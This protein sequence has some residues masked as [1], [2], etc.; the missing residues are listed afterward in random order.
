MAVNITFALITHINVL[1]KNTVLLCSYLVPKSQ[2]LSGKQLY[3]T[4]YLTGHVMLLR[5]EGGNIELLLIYTTLFSFQALVE[6]PSSEAKK[7]YRYL[8]ID[9]DKSSSGEML[10]NM[11]LF[12]YFFQLKKT[13]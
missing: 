10:I 2:A 6:K 9:E 13:R 4:V 1:N 12:I 5:G 7:T 3:I 11:E 8:I